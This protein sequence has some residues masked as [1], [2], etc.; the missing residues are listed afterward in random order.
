MHF[1]YLIGK[2]SIWGNNE[3]RYSLRSL[4]NY[5]PISS[6]AIVGNVPAFARN[7][8]RIPMEETGIDKAERVGG[9][10]LKALPLLPERFV[11]MNDDFYLLAKMDTLPTYHMGLIRSHLARV[12]RITS[13]YNKRRAE[14]L[15]ILT[16]RQFTD[17]LDFG[18]H[19]PFPVE[20]DKVQQLA[21]IVP[22]WKR[23][24]FRSLYGNIFR[25][26]LNL[27][28]MSDCKRQRPMVG[29]FY[30]SRGRVSTEVKEF[31][32]ERFCTPSRF[33]KETA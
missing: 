14:T 15:D 19:V 22:F 25:V 24:L 9:R 23:G 10:L 32:T 7:V 28:R 20:R 33:E 13:P 30:S 18:V 4:E 31:L 26:A 5:A 11:L 8:I 17:P 27:A 1:V 2:G 29:P 16:R 21:E 6:V 3:L 12:R